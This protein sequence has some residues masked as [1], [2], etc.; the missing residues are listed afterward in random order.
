[1]ARLRK[2]SR[3]FQEIARAFF[4]LRGAPFVL[5]SKDQ[6]TIATWEEEG[7]PL[8][9]VL[10]GLRRA[11]DGYRKQNPEGKMPA[12]SFCHHEVMKAFE[13]YRERRVGRARKV[14]SREEK[15]KR[16]W[17]EVERFRRE[18]PSRWN[19]LQPILD[20]AL[21]LLSGPAVVE[22]ELERLEEKL[23]AVLLEQAPEEEKVEVRRWVLAELSG[24]R[25]AGFEQAYSIRLVKSL[26]Q[27]LKIPHFPLY[28]Y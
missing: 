23:E 26:R 15:R 1:M 17:A 25:Q 22:E 11:F 10:E 24:R 27:K 3:Y 9:I 14:V 2:R 7:V 20:E 8:T 18:L 13:E 4:D 28:Y 5:S 6:M 19:H 21:R 12:L 16:V